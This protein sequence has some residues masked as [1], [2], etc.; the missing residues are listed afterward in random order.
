MRRPLDTKE[1]IRINAV[2]RTLVLML[3]ARRSKADTGRPPASMTTRSREVVT[4]FEQ[5]ALDATGNG[6]VNFLTEDETDRVAA[7]YGENYPRLQ[8]I[9]R[10]VDPDNLFRVNL[11]IRPA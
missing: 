11:N 6:Y 9:K 1:V 4:V 7:S 8:A 10:R 2:L 5:L 3:P